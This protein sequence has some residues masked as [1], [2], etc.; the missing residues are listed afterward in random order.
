MFSTCRSSWRQEISDSILLKGCCS[1][2]PG[3]ECATYEK[4][5]KSWN[6]GTLNDRSATGPS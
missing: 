6:M 1:V 4:K 5:V 2:S 3:V